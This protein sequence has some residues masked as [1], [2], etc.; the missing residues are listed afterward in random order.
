MKHAPQNF[1]GRIPQTVIRKI[2][3]I[4]PP[5]IRQISAECIHSTLNLKFKPSGVYRSVKAFFSTAQILKFQR[6]K[7][8]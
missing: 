6:F 1:T 5:Q 7:F 2:P 3:H 4:P 8:S